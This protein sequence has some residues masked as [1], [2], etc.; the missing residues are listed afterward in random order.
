MKQESVIEKKSF[1]FALSI[2]NLTR[3]IQNHHEEYILSKQLLRSG[4]SIGACIREAA[5][6][7]SKKDFVHKMSLALKEANE[8]KY[9]LKLL[10][11]SKFVQMSKYSELKYSITEI[12]K[13]LTAIV[14]S[15][16][17]NLASS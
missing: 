8:S 11:C 4:T 14:K 3:K 2:V 5:Y 10:Y 12:V 16:K 7:E 1:E 15:A 9:W 17:I 13:I 6:A